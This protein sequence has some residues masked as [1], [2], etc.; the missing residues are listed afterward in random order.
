MATATQ[1]LP[2][3]NIQAWRA[4]MGDFMIGDEEL[5][6]KIGQVEKA[7]TDGETGHVLQGHVNVMVLKFIHCVRTKFK[8]LEAEVEQRFKEEIRAALA[9]AARHQQFNTSGTSNRKRITDSKGAAMMTNYSGEKADKHTFREWSDK[10]VNQFSVVYPG[11]RSLYKTVR[12]QPNR[13]RKILSGCERI[14]RSQN[15]IGQS[16]AH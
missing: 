5:L 16:A 3:V 9:E 8:N 7:I 12:Y 6:L 11:S 4:D 10:L 2:D 1:L 13:D 14:C 15:P